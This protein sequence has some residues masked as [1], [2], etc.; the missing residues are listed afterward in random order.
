MY[1][2]DTRVKRNPKELILYL[3]TSKIKY[4]NLK[5]KIPDVESGDQR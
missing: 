3:V 4:A 1:D 5:M 2:E